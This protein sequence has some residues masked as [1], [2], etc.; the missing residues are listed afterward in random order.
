MGRI[1]TA[2]LALSLV[3]PACSGDDE[4]LGMPPPDPDPVEVRITSPADGALLAGT[5]LLVTGEVSGTSRTEVTIN[6]V[7]VPAEA[8]V[9]AYFMPIEDGPMIITVTHAESGASDTVA[10]TVDGRPPRLKIEEPARATLVAEGSSIKLRVTADDEHALKRVVAAG[11]ELDLAEGPEWELDC[12][13]DAGLNTLTLEAEDEAGNVATEHVNVLSGTFA[14]QMDELPDALLIHI[15]VEA[16]EGLT[17]VLGYLI[18]H[19]DFASTVQDQNPLLD[20]D[21]YAVSIAEVSVQPG[22]AVEIRPTENRLEVGLTILGLKASGELKL[23]TTGTLLGLT[24]EIEQTDLLVPLGI[25]PKDGEYEVFLDPPIF[26]FVQPIVTLSDPEGGVSVAAIEGPL[27][28]S[29]EKLLTDTA[30]AMGAEALQ[31][32]L[33]KLADPI[34]TEM[35]PIAFTV[36]LTAIEASIREHGIE[37]RLSGSVQIDG[38]AVHT[39]DPGVFGTPNDPLYGP[40]GP[41]VAIALSD[42]LLN[43][44]FHGL[45]RVGVLDLTVDQQMLDDI[46]AHI[47]LVVG[48]LGGVAEQVDATMDPETPMTVTLMPLLQPVMAPK[49]GSDAIAVA[50]G[51]LSLSFH[52]GS[53]PLLTG[54]LTL[55]LA[56]GAMTKLGKLAFEVM[57]F[58]TAFDLDVEDPEVK[59]MLEA[60]VDPVVA[61]LLNDLGPLLQTI[62]APIAVPEFAGFEL[63][64]ASLGDDG[65]DGAYLVV[66]GVLS[67]AVGA[68][69]A[70][71]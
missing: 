9:F 56:L 25:V 15:G 62:V 49:Q 4:P 48:F 20:S 5:I 40:R 42:D 8:G 13:L 30:V 26:E 55:R 23:K 7:S 32:V 33:S 70:D 65:T 64:P 35:G 51:D 6:D 63:T 17:S 2:V 10:V 47:A 46:S 52:T 29:L 12:A 44:I 67:K 57:P 24:L 36:D 11:Q 41:D 69:A 16:L 22:T 18:D 38:E 50:V 45:W 28:Q 37:L 68:P 60:S 19:F 54:F 31:A 14:P 61:A 34:T 71:Q 39:D 58:Q 53:G 59:R 1:Q 43:T 3:L 21:L 66:R 27:L